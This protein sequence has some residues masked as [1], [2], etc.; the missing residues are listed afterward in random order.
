MSFA[1]RLIHE[2]TLVRAPYQ[3]DPMTNDEYNQPVV[4]PASSTVR[5]LVQPRPASRE[6]ADTRSAGSE[7]ADH[8]IFLAPMDLNAAD[9]FVRGDERFEIV[10]IRRFEFGR[11]P[12]LEVDARRV[13]GALI[14]TGS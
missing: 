4:V 1:A 13:T 3:D 2:L 14:A 12:H 7:V 5:G 10:G 9:H 11:S 6:Q 8:V